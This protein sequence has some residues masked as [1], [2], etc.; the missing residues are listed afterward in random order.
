MT[1][2]I[3][4]AILACALV[5]SCSESDNIT[6]INQNLFSD[7]PTLEASVIVE[8]INE[9]GDPVSDAAVSLGTE[10]ALTDDNGEVFFVDHPLGSSAF[11]VV[12]HDQYFHGSRRFYPTE[13]GLLKVKVMLLE[14]TSAC[15][16]SAT[17][18]GEVKIDEEVTLNFEPNSVVTAN[19]NP[20]RGV[21][22]VFAKAL[23]ADHEHIQDIMPGDL[24]GEDADG[25]LMG[26]ETYG[27]V[28]VELRGL[29]GEELQ[30]ADG[31]TVEMSMSVPEELRTTAPAKIP[32][33]YFDEVI[34]MWLEEGEAVLTD[35]G[36]IG[37]VSHFS[38]WNCD[39]PFEPVRWEASFAHESGPISYPLRVCIEV[40]GSNR[41]FCKLTNPDGTIQGIVAAGVELE[42]TA[43]SPCGDIVFEDIIGPYSQNTV[44][45][46]IS[47]PEISQGKTRFVGQITDCDGEFVSNGVI[48]VVSGHE[49]YQVTASDDGTFGLDLYDQCIASGVV[50]LTAIDLDRIKE[51]I[52]VDPSK[53]YLD[54]AD[55]VINLGQILVCDND[56][57]E[58]IILDY[59]GVRTFAWFDGFRVIG[60]N[61]VHTIQAGLLDTIFSSGFSM[62]LPNDFDSPILTGGA[63]LS[64]GDSTGRYESGGSVSVNVISSGEKPLGVLQGNFANDFWDRRDST[65]VPVTCSYR[66][67]R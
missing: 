34:G 30:V 16:I 10:M 23:P 25:R 37:D 31:S 19:G 61:V 4:I 56:V 41:P 58:Y 60:G 22:S 63:T 20:Y 67:I 47:L 51:A 2:R 57:E 26:L 44:I 50:S 6:P 66:V 48:K 18:G 15:V 46:P 65:Y 8:V 28:A 35:A 21:I 43:Q 40:K 62:T 39:F 27:M 45:G 55:P 52:S 24:V 42:M 49:S 38:F 33:W 32:L 64:W 12:D 5:L 13:S 54:I 29:T 7:T 11:V 53:D 14:K 36:Y 3:F 9:N 59:G 17:A 1:S